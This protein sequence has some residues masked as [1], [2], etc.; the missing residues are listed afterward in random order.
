MSQQ[1]VNILKQLSYSN[2]EFER[3]HCEQVLQRFT[4]KF[5]LEVRDCPAGKNNKNKNSGKTLVAI[6]AVPP[7]NELLAEMRWCIHARFA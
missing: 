5:D 7:S 3:D 4:E 1:N 2:W 6:F